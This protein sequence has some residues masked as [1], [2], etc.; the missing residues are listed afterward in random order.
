MNEHPVSGTSGD[1]GYNPN[2][3]SPGGNS[4]VVGGNG[5]DRDRIATR[6]A[7]WDRHARP[8][9]G[10]LPHRMETRRDETIRAGQHHYRPSVNRAPE[11]YE[12]TNTLAIAGG[13][14]VGGL[15]LGWLLASRSSDNHRE[16]EW[17]QRWEEPRYVPER[18]YQPRQEYAGRRSYSSKEPVATDET[19]DLIASDKVEGTA[20]YDRKGERLGSV[21]NFMV[22][23]RSGKVAYAVMSFGGW[24]GMGESYHPVPWSTLTYDTDRGGYVVGLTKESLRNAPSHRADQDTSSDASYWRGVSAYWA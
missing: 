24:L 22:G 20:V 23:K 5:P 14:I 18:S 6:S 17:D 16:R 8:T 19:R 11:W 4:P 21:Y 7:D 1:V 12:D 3:I 10:D 9:H 2:V 13:G 15:L